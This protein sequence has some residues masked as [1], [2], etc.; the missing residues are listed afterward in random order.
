[1]FAYLKKSG[2]EICLSFGFGVAA[3]GSLLMTLNWQAQNI[4]V[5]IG[6]LV[7]FA[8]A[9]IAIVG[10]FLGLR[11]KN[12]QLIVQNIV[13][14]MWSVLLPLILLVTKFYQ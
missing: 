3:I 10:V 4:V 12:G 11:D 8:A 7:M 13:I 5:F 2:T 6:I 1:M 9:I 14:L